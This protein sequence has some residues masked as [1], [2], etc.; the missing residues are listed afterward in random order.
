MAD[1]EFFEIEESGSLAFAAAEPR[2][3]VVGQIRIGAFAFA[4]GD[5]FELFPP[6]TFF[7]L[8]DFA[9]L[10][11]HEIGHALGLA[12]SDVSTALMRGYV[13]S[14]FDGGDCHWT[15]PDADGL[16]PITRVPKADDIAGIQHLYGVPEP[17]L[18]AM[19]AAGIAA[20]AGLGRSRARAAAHR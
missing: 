15:D 14:G 17:G 16:A 1:I 13:D 3:A 5:P 2:I 12:H 10:V 7:Y 9:G 19:T 11:A 18:S 20:L 4:E 8:N 6:P